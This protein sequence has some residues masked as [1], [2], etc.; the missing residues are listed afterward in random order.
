[1][2]KTG[3]H[4]KI[5][6]LGVASALIFSLSSCGSASKDREQ[7]K[8]SGIGE[9]E[10]GN[11][12]AAEKDFEKALSL[13]GLHVS[14]EAVDLNYYKAL[15]EYL[16]GKKD[17]ALKTAE[18]L[19]SYD[20]KDP[21][22]FYLRGSL[23]LSSGDS[24]KALSDYR[25]SLSLAPKDYERYLRISQNLSNAGET[26]DSK[27]I[28]N[29]L[30][31][32]ADDSRQGL[33]ASGDAERLLGNASS[34][35]KNY[36]KALKK[37]NAEARISLA[38]LYLGTG[39][40]EQAKKE[41]DS[42]EKKEKMTP[43]AWNVKGEY[44]FSQKKYKEALKAFQSG[45]KLLKESGKNDSDDGSVKMLLSRNEIA[46]LEYTGDF[47]GAAGKCKSYLSLYPFDQGMASEYL[48]LQTR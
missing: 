41:L 35:R 19:I 9:M 30:K 12:A 39:K 44:Y 36:Q 26:E 14:S 11:Y 7:L 20:E 46:A 15:S 28:L 42:Y 24:K 2:K 40:P 1:M 38:A 4:R 23:Y 21:D 3:M 29:L 34:A 25:K 22:G 32:N 48:F 37:G 6:I 5:V 45:E 16:Q 17:E 27:E 33:L 13:S 10:S 18:G 8:Q 43:S 31:K 47:K